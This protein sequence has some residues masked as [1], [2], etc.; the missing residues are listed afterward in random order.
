MKDIYEIKIKRAKELKGQI[1]SLYWKQL[2]LPEP[3]NLM[4]MGAYLGDFA[5]S[6]RSA[7]NYCMRRFAEIKIK[8][9]LSPS[10]YKVIEKR[11]DFPWSEDRARF[12]KKPIISHI[13]IHFGKA[14]Q[15]LESIQPYHKENEWLKHLM[16]ISNMDKHVNI[17]EIDPTEMFDAVAINPDGTAHPKPR[18]VKGKL[19]VTSGDKY[20]F[21]SL[22]YYYPPYYAFASKEGK[23]I[24]FIID[25][26][27]PKPL[28]KWF[29]ENAPK[30][31]RA[32]INGLDALI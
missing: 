22:P 14:Y 10:D 3:H 7:L 12:D 13:R 15:F 6:L 26:D 1:E 23:W 17:I 18:F 24:V 20:Y 5:N 21:Y 29:I 25:I 30:K 2:E 16:K 19:L 27:N 11:L 8:P 9:V 4:E 31:V 32:L 28:L